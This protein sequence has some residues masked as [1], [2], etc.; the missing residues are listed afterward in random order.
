MT[1]TM[2]ASSSMGTTQQGKRKESAA[3]VQHSKRQHHS[4]GVPYGVAPLQA[5]S[6][7]FPITGVSGAAARWSTAAALGDAGRAAALPLPLWVG[8]NAP[9]GQMVASVNGIATASAPQMVTTNGVATSSTPQ[10]ASMNGVV[11]ASVPQMVTANDVATWSTP[12]MAS[13]SQMV[14]ANGVT[15]SSTPQMASVNG[16]VTASAPQT[17]TANGVETMST[18]LVFAQAAGQLVP[19]PVQLYGYMPTVA[20]PTGATPLP[21][22]AALTRF[23]SA[24][25]A[26]MLSELMAVCQPPVKQHESRNNT[27]PRW[28]PT[29]AEPWW[30]A[31]VAAHLPRIPMPVPFVAA[32]LL[33]KAHR[34]AVL[35]AMVKHLSPDFG[36]IAAAVRRCEMSASEAALWDSA[37]GNE[38]AP[39][40]RPVYIV[41]M[42]HLLPPGQALADTGG[43]TLPADNAAGQVVVA[44]ADLVEQPQEMQGGVGVHGGVVPAVGYQQVAAILAGDGGAHMAT[45][46]A[47]PTEKVRDQV[48]AAEAEPEKP[49][50]E[51]GGDVDATFFFPESDLLEQELD[52]MLGLAPFPT[53]QADDPHELALSDQSGKD[54]EASGAAAEAEEEPEDR[55]WYQN[56]EQR[57][58]FAN[59]S[60]GSPHSYDDGWYLF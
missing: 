59:I 47:M 5:A 12:H 34:V 3:L 36:R 6:M 48:A 22:A 13:A 25:L 45:T 49:Q 33:K 23:H 19:V 29:A 53:E 40:G 32:K 30:A 46:V 7:A 17:V 27:P 39:C 43:V 54:I 57:S 50:P 18:P 1:A 58:L 10:M 37:L 26:R 21:L 24:T 38:Q 42:Q 56:E 11:T 35:V 20:G 44:V 4:Y 15:T 9:A 55:P 51:Q 14:T 2:G 60:L 41:Q 16:I 52:D 28:W 31:E 8:A